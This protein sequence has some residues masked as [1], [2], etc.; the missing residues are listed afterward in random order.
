[1][2]NLDEKQRVDLRAGVVIKRGAVSAEFDRDVHGAVVGLISGDQI[3]DHQLPLALNLVS[4]AE[5][6][7]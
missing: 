4:S 2:V 7:Y 1:M 5:S 6:K 3:H